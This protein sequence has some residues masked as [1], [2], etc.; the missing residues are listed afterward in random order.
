[1]RVPGIGGPR[2]VLAAALAALEAEGLAVEV[3]APVI[4]S[5]P[6]GPSQRRF[7]NGAAVVGTRLAPPEVLRLLQGME[8]AFGRK[9]RGQ[10]WRA[11][12]LDLDIV[13]WSGGAWLSPGLLVPHRAFRSRPFVLGPAARIA[14]AWRDPGTG[15]TLRQLH[16]RLTRPRPLPR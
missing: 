8:R 16:A 10:R 11:R 12:P 15:L 4:T 3:A 7:A 1:M 14:S 9:R 13:L 5:A 6:V 2:G